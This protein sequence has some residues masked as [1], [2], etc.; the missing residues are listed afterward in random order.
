M[1]NIDDIYEFISKE[2]LERIQK[3]M[4][5]K[6]DDYI[7]VLKKKVKTPPTKEESPKK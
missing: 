3:Q 4:G 5:L 1:Y 7:D 2:E 6:K